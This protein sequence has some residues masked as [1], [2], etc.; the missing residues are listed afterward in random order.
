MSRWVPTKKEKYG[1]AIYNYDA[2]GEE[3]LSLQI[4]DT[5]HILETHE[6]ERRAY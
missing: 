3:E 1:V 6:G 2:R 5:V 4:G